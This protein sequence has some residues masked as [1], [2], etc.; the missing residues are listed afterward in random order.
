MKLRE[1]I[2]SKKYENNHKVVN[3][4]GIKFKIRRKKQDKKITFLN[5]TNIEPIY[6]SR[7]PLCGEEH[8]YFIKEYDINNLIQ[9]WENQFS[10]NPISNCY[11]DKILQ[12]RECS[13]CGLQYYNYGIPDTKEMYSHLYSMHKT[14]YSKNK[15]EYDI[16]LQFVKK[17]N[18]Q[19]VMDI[20]CG[21]GYFLE[22]LIN[23][24]PDLLGQEFNPKAFADA[25]SRL[26]EG[27]KIT[28]DSLKQ[29][30]KKFDIIFSF[31]VFEHVNKPEEF[32]EDVLNLL[33]KNGYL[34]L[35]T[36]N[37]DSALIRNCPGILELPPHHCID[38]TKSAFEYIAKE[39]NLEITEY[40]ESE[41]E[42]WEWKN[43]MKAKYNT[44]VN[45]NSHYC[46][47]LKERNQLTGKTHMVCFKKR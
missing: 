9:K 14:Y 5:N 16:A 35:S 12:R 15:W 29:I 18:P 27:G 46:E 32:I 2:F 20:G 13:K 26:G 44:D 25:D 6:V 42:F 45:I 43:Y 19:A 23:V 22:K 47:Y 10:L 17:Y 7:C 33:N 24:V 3:F 8:Y 38:V 28:S 11:R 39:Y 36:P 34:V 30:K 21:A 1:F 41:M 37:P 40:L 4:M 31:Q